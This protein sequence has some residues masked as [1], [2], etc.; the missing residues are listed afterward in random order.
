MK[1]IFWNCN[2]IRDP[3]KP[4]FIFET[5]SDYRLDFI[6]LLD[7]RRNDF[8]LEELAHFCANRNFLWDWTPPR[9]RSGDILLGVNKE[10][11]EVLDIKHGNFTL[12]FKLRNK[13]DNFE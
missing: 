13:E 4:R 8:R 11:F 5:A 3:A 2:G 6:A 12:K 7:T 10:K 1:G 9:G